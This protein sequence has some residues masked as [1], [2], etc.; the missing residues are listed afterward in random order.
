MHISKIILL[1]NM[2]FKIYFVVE[3]SKKFIIIV[4]DKSNLNILFY[5][6]VSKKKKIK[7]QKYLEWDQTFNLINFRLWTCRI[8]EQVFIQYVI[9]FKLVII[10]NYNITIHYSYTLPTSLRYLGMYETNSMDNNLFFR[11]NRQQTRLC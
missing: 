6:D 2:T 8:F 11:L 5:F 3:K 1:R 4:N 9:I 7:N 10:I